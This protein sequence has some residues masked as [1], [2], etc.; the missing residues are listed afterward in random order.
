MV[1]IDARVIVQSAQKENLLLEVVEII[2]PV[3]CSE[4]NERFPDTV[5]CDVHKR[6][7]KQGRQTNKN[8]S[9]S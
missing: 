6:L 2:K 4:C 3:L 5:T 9:D 7:H 8:A 1:C